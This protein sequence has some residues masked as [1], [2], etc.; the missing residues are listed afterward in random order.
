MHSPAIGVQDGA[1]QAAEEEEEP[2][3]ALGL[4]ELWGMHSQIWGRPSS[5]PAQGAVGEGPS[6]L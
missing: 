5:P 6:T 3:E 1:Q 4:A 2:R